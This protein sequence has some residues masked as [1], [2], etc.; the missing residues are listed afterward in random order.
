MQKSYRLFGLKLFEIS[1][2]EPESRSE[3][4]I[5]NI[6]SPII[7]INENNI[8]SLSAV[9]SA[10]RIVSETLAMLPVNV[11][12]KNE[13]GR[14]IAV[15]H[16]LQYLLHDKPH[17]EI[18]SFIWREVTQAHVELWGNSYSK[19]IRDNNGVVRELQLIPH[20]LLVDPFIYEGEVFY[21]I[22]GEKLPLPSRDILHF[23][24]LSFDG[25]KGK[26]V[27]TVARETISNALAMQEYANTVF[28]KG[29]AKRI[30]LKTPNRVS[31]ETY[32]RLKKQFSDRYA[33]Y[34]K[35]NDIAILEGGL[36]FTAI[37]ID[38]VD[39][40]FI[41]QRK[42]SVIE[43]AR[44]FRIPPH[45]MQSMES[46][47]NNNIEHQAIEFVTDTMMPRVARF[48]AELNTKLFKPGDKMYVKFNLNAIMRGDMAA[49]GEWYTKMVNFGIMSPNEVRELEELNAREG[50]DIYMSPA[51]LMTDKQRENAL[52]K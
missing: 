18:N 29:S 52:P 51:N 40:Q 19:I 27:M 28:T 37:G 39:A 26:G 50:G 42:F 24:G 4:R 38:P 11:F 8:T 41:E 13:S 46:S 49:R 33:G 6:S 47:T 22:R 14:N 10:V 17:P 36:D 15:D 35:I 20:P 31:D 34:N 1:Q 44:F 16:P 30:A 3:V 9:W 45:K 23:K 21:N 25:L 2:S 12:Q 48:E 7:G 32:N 5:E 43:I